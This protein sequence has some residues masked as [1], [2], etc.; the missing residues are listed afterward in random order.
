MPDGEQSINLT[1]A[2]IQQAARERE[3]ERQEEQEAITEAFEEEGALGGGG[4]GTTDTATDSGTN[5]V[6]ETADTAGDVAGDVTDTAAETAEPVTDAAGEA[7]AAVGGAVETVTGDTT[8]TDT[9]ASQQRQQDTQTGLGSAVAEQVGSIPGAEAVGGAVGTATDPVN[10]DTGQAAE[11]TD[12]SVATA[13]RNLAGRREAA[14]ENLRDRSPAEIREQVR[15][16]NPQAQNIEVERTAQGFRATFEQPQEEFDPVE[17]GARGAVESTTGVDLPTEQELV[18]DTRQGV[19]DL[20]GVDVPSEREVTTE[21]RTFVGGATGV[22]IPSEQELSTGL[23]TDVGAATGVDLPG[24]EQLTADLQAGTEDVTGV[25]PGAAE[26]LTAGETVAATAPAAATG[27]PFGAAAAGGIALGA[28]IVASGDALTGRT[29]DVPVSEQVFPS[30]TGTPTGG[31]FGEELQPTGDAEPTGGPEVPATGGTLFDSELS[32]GDGLPQSDLLLPGQ[33]EGG[34]TA[35]GTETGGESVVPGNF[36][37][38]GRDLPA[39]PSQDFTGGGLVFGTSP[40][41]IG[42]ERQRERVDDSL[43]GEDIP[44][45]LPSPDQPPPSVREQIRRD[46]L[47]TPER[48]FPTGEQAV[49]GREVPT[50]E[51]TEGQRERVE[52]A[53]EPFTQGFVGPQGGSTLLPGAADRQE[54]AQGQGVFGEVRQSPVG[55]TVTGQ[56][57]GLLPETGLG[58]DADVTPRTDQRQRQDQQQRQE[59]RTRQRNRTQPRETTAPDFPNPFGNRFTEEFERPP[60]TTPAASPPAGATVRLPGMEVPD[61]DDDEVEPILPA[62]QTF[63]NPVATG[64]EFLFGGGGG[65]GGGGR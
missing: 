48:N 38:P 59:Q 24:Q 13:V 21:S 17:S 50:D 29:T 40:T 11:P 7:G 9:Q 45:D 32:V 35:G 2:D 33:S 20:I 19:G 54:R 27:G 31:L 3:R 18:A 26:D 51:A 46:D 60:A 65:F 37:L 34:T 5:V 49:A 53:Q 61:S 58:V 43:T 62:G 16:E 39:D 28:G 55:D 14:V 1:Q 10:F 42:Q 22:D 4:G 25:D 64:F 12:R 44:T 36:P 8:D 57:P 23:R 52:Q 15:E 63:T 47:L 30:D 56:V 41:L 6:E